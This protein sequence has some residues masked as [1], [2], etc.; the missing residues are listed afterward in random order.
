[1]RGSRPYLGSHFSGSQ[2]FVRWCFRIASIASIPGATRPYAPIHRVAEKAPSRLLR[3]S[4][5]MSS[6]RPLM[7]LGLLPLRCLHVEGDAHRFGKGEINRAA[8]LPSLVKLLDIAFA[9][10]R[11]HPDVEADVL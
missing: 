6:R 11:L 5:M 2:L 8:L 10:G 9:V 1:M 7:A 4:D 3:A